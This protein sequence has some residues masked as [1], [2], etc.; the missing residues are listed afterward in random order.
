M[1]R[2]LLCVMQGLVLLALTGL[3]WFKL[4]SGNFEAG[5]AVLL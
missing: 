1:L 3:K 5:I 2:N 4:K